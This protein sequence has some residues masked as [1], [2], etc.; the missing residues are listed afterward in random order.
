MPELAG[1]GRGRPGGGG[2]A[3]LS[4]QGPLS[5]SVP[6][7]FGVTHSTLCLLPRHPTARAQP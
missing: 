4:H 6:K 1:R 3:G 7:P 5:K 2:G